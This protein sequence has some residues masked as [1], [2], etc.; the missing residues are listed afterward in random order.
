ML[1][2]SEH[3]GPIRT[4]WRLG[5]ATTSVALL[6]CA[7]GAPLSAQESGAVE[8][9]EGLDDL[10]DSD[11]WEGIEELV[12]TGGSR[13]AILE[14]ATDSA[15]SFDAFELQQER[16]GDV[17]DVAS[18]TP[19]LEIKSAFAASNPTLFIRGIGLDDYNANSA[20]AVAVY[21]DGVYM[22]SPAGQLFQFFDT[23]RVEV[24]RGPQAGRLRNAA[25]GAILVQSKKP[26][27]DH[28]AYA[29]LTY[30]NYNLIEFESAINV[31]VIEG[32]LSSRFSGKYTQRDGYTKNRCGGQPLVNSNR[33]SVLTDCYRVP[34]Q[35]LGQEPNPFFSLGSNPQ[36]IHSRVNDA[37]NWA[38]RAQLL[39]TPPWVESNA[40]WLLNVHGGQ[41]LGQA[42]QYQHRAFVQ[43]N[44]TD[45][46]SPRLPVRRD[47]EPAIDS[48]GYRDTDGDPFAGAYNN[49]G[50][51]ELDLFGANVSGTWEIS[52]G[53]NVF[54]LSAYE[55][56][57]RRTLENSDGNPRNLLTSL[58]VDNAWQFSQDLRID[59]VWTE[60]FETSIGGYFIRETLSVDNEYETETFKLIQDYTQ[61]LR[62]WALYGDVLW[63]FLDD[64]TFEGSVRYTHEYKK[65][66]NFSSAAVPSGPSGVGLS[67]G[68]KSETFADFSG[69]VSFTWNVTDDHSVHVKYTRGWKPGHFNGGSVFSGILIEPI[70]PEELNAYEVGAKLAFYDGSLTL[71][72]AGFYYDFKN[73]QI[74]AL[75]QDDRSFALPQL[76]NAQGAEVLGA[77]LELRFRPAGRWL[78]GLDLRVNAA[79]LDTEYTEFVNILFR[80]RPRIGGNPEPVPIPVD[81]TG[82]E[83]IGSPRWSVN[84]ALQ[85]TLPLRFGGAADYGELIPRVSITWKDDTFYDASGGKGQLQLLP[86]STIGQEAYWLGNASLLW[87]SGNQK[88]ELMAWVKNFMNE[89]Y[90]LQSFDL[91]DGFDLVIDVY[92][93]P[94]TLGATLSL[95]F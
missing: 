64:V 14:G 54:S 80:S 78:E 11:P 89:E 71:D 83:L 35:T 87:R 22:N 17:S 81:N 50:N 94:R 72:L 86:G 29:R 21:Q 38:G 74:F 27:F 84:G 90:K 31:P 5:I 56:H 93:Q 65:F 49:G 12:V 75:E 92:G 25:A 42:T 88:L 37:E 26:T 55:W 20:S 7:L 68:T 2:N 24:L 44:P 61:E 76:I 82:N 8:Q 33:P 48:T 46:S 52:E 4:K 39:F 53:H 67:V 45:P 47:G 73:L 10:D 57:D 6:L 32:V 9:I 58:Y 69:L 16:I 15:I 19:N 36:K 95:Y 28:E 40:E 34:S 18:L 1:G 79:F 59:S 13:A 43:S 62:S 51:E 85:Y 91:S 63:D 70:E 41:N 60:G 66:E 3:P 77:E 23:G 30:G